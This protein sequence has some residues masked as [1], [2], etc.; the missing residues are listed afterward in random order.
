MWGE[1]EMPF[2]NLTGTFFKTQQCLQAA[3]QG[4]R[5]ASLSQQ[6]KCG[7][8]GAARLIPVRTASTWRGSLSAA[9]SLLTFSLECHLTHLS[10]KLLTGSVPGSVIASPSGCLVRID[11]K[12]IKHL[13]QHELC[14]CILKNEELLS[15]ISKPDW[16]EKLFHSLYR[17]E[18]LSSLVYFLVRKLVD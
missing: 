6:A 14:M 10:Q 4:L 9:Y 13:L 17:R 16:Q 18:V 2:S 12:C 5:Q 3:A 15:N 11:A 7:W 1:F 8:D